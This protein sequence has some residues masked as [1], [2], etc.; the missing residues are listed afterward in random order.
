MP[1]PCWDDALTRQLIDT[2]F[3]AAEKSV[4]KIAPANVE[5]TL[6]NNRQL[7]DMMAEYFMGQAL[8]THYPG[9]YPFHLLTDADKKR[10]TN[11]LP[12]AKKTPDFVMDATDLDRCQVGDAFTTEDE[13]SK[14]HSKGFAKYY[15]KKGGDYRSKEAFATKVWEEDSAQRGRQ[16]RERILEKIRKYGDTLN[17]VVVVGVAPGAEPDKQTLE[18]V[19][20][21]VTLFTW[22]M[23]EGTLTN[24]NFQA[25]KNQ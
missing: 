15:E 5:A 25:A 17:P 9:I 11:R 21:R 7:R 14:I 12:D 16:F 23:G 19:K 8:A 20:D 3:A 1:Y 18:E 6:L 13:F 10:V 4:G 24:V 22:S 2:E